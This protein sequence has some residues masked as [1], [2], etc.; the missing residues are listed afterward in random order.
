[1][2]AKVASSE[3][4]HINKR[5]L[6]LERNEYKKSEIEFKKTIIINLKNRKNKKV[7]FIKPIIVQKVPE[8]QIFL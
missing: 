5:K 3:E 2:E 7:K 8:R 6:H 1:M 4:F